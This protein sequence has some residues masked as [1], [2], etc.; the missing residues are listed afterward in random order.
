M[1]IESVQVPKSNLSQAAMAAMSPGIVRLLLAFAVVI[2]HMSSFG[3]GRWAVE[4]FFVLSGFWVTLMYRRKYLRYRFSPL[5]FYISRYLRLFPILLI[6]QVALLFFLYEAHSPEISTLT[7]VW[8]LRAFLLV[9][10]AHEHV[11]LVPSWSLDVEAQFYLLLPLLVLL[12]NRLKDQT[13]ARVSVLFAI[14]LFPLALLPSPESNPWVFTY[15]TFFLLGIA[16]AYKPWI[17]SLKVAMISLTA[18]VAGTA[19]ITILPQT[20][21]LIMG[22]QHPYDPSLYAH[23]D[24]LCAVLALI[25]GP[26]LLYSLSIRSSSLDRR[27]GNMAYPMYLVHWVIPVMLVAVM[28]RLSPMKFRLFDIVLVLVFSVV[29]EL[30][31]DQVAEKQRERFMKQTFSESRP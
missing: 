10:S 31:V 13:A 19:A 9:G 16:Q 22:G 17:P 1:A 30:L 12:L 25:I 5:A 3:I 15:S 21:G 27:L 20:R 28:G 11:L 14:L 26:F 23:N 18:F 7:P 24:Q 6:C 8:I 4:V 29:L 2:H